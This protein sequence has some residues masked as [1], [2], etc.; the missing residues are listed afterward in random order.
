MKSFS[1]NQVF[2]HVS[3][4]PSLLGLPRRDYAGESVLHPWTSGHCS[5]VP[6]KHLYVILGVPPH[7]LHPFL[8]FHGSSGSSFSAQPRG[9]EIAPAQD[10]GFTS[11]AP[12]CG[13]GGEEILYVMVNSEKIKRERRDKKK[14]R[15][16]AIAIQLGCSGKVHWERFGERRRA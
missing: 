13:G 3:S 10:L 4:Y 11:I 5:C 12:G 14:P 9:F 6:L 15:R 1:H 2:R 8:P 16:K 7:D